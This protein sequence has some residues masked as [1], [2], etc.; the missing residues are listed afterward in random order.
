MKMSP[1]TTFTVPLPKTL[2]VFSTL[3][4]AKAATLNIRLVASGEQNGPAP[5]IQSISIKAQ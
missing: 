1:Q 2:R 5:A 4:A 3:G